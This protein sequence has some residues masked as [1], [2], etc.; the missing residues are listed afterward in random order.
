MRR[1]F[2]CAASL[3]VMTLGWAVQH[4]ALA[5]AKCEP[6]AVAKKYPSLAG[7]TIIVAQAGEGAPFSFR[8]PK[9]FN[10]LIGFDADIVRAAF[11]CIGVKF[12]FKIG[13]WSGL[14][15]APSPA[16]PT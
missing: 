12:E 15:P 1:A 6:E 3:L 13:A 9:D 5:Q 8:D 10:T 4:A 11:A 14:L 7:K 2:F 16:R